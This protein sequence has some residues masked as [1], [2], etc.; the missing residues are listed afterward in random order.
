MAKVNGR[1]S[2]RF[3][4]IETSALA[5][6]SALEGRG[7]FFSTARTKQTLLIRPQQS[8]T[9]ALSLGVLLQ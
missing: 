9:D 8:S 2:T 5:L 6:P 1:T 3:L 7:C 4:A